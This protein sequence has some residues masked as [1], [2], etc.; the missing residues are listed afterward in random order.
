[1]S[2]VSCKC[3]IGLNQKIKYIICYINR[4]NLKNTKSPQYIIYLWKLPVK[5][6]TTIHDKNSQK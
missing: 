1:M 2:N 6:I 3:K 4:I 5:N